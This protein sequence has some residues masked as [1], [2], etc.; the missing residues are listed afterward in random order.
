[1]QVSIST[2]QHINQTPASFEV[3]LLNNPTII[4]QKS[5]NH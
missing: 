1:M 3:N 4:E 2:E 5:K